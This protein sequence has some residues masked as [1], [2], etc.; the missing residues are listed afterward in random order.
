MVQAEKRGLEDV[1][2]RVE[3]QL[4]TAVEE[5]TALADRLETIEER[6]KELLKVMGG[7][8]RLMAPSRTHARGGWHPQA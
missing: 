3:A 5:K 7:R 4:K 8:L 1:A 2:Q 6:Y